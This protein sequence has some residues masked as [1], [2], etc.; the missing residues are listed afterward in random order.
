[1][2]Y[3]LINKILKRIFMSWIQLFKVTSFG[4]A[5]K[6]RRSGIFPAPPLLHGHPL[7]KVKKV[8]SDCEIPFYFHKKKAQGLNN[9]D[10]PY[11][12][13]PKGIAKDEQRYAERVLK[14]RQGLANAKEKELKWRQEYLNRRP[15]KGVN[16]LIKKI[17]PFVIKQ[18]AIKL[19]EDRRRGGGGRKMVSEHV[20]GVPRGQKTMTKSKK[21]VVKVMMDNKIISPT[22]LTAMAKGK[23][24]TSKKGI[25]DKQ[26]DKKEQE[27]KALEQKKREEQKKK[28]AKLNMKVETGINPI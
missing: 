22:M 15:Y 16:E 17:M 20:K 11:H 21:E 10:S 6:M 5:L 14:L 8:F 28:D 9:I 23:S 2:F 12:K 26:K 24:L 7:N 3:I 1:L 19:D 18:Q 13:L 25:S 27:T 4:K